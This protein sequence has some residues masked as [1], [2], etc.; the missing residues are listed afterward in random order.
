MY[1]ANTW[2]KFN[3]VMTP[4]EFKAIFGRD[5]YEFVIHNTRVGID[6]THTEKQEIFSA[7]RLYF[8]KIL[9]NAS[10]HDHT[11]LNAIVDT[12]RLGMTVQTRNLSFPEVVPGGQ[13]SE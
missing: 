4:Q 7:Y 13:V 3:Y 5:D 12:M 10:V 1:I 9:C 8:V 6:Y 11:T 2:H